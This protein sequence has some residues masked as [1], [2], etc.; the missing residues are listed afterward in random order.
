[1]R[2]VEAG[3]LRHPIL[4]QQLRQT[5]S[6]SGQLVETFPDFSTVWASIEPVTAKEI[7]NNQ[8]VKEQITHKI[9]IRYIAGLNSTF[10]IIYNGRVFDITSVLNYDELNIYQT[11][12]AT[13]SN[14]HA[15]YFNFCSGGVAVG[16]T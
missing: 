11:I 10:R 14:K 8:Q 9:T 6:A 7:I 4:I 2:T 3:K 16:G 1:M 13:E 15:S 5:A 12:L